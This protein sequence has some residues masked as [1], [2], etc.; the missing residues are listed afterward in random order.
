MSKTYLELDEVDRLEEAAGYLRDKLLIRVLFHLG[1]RISEA[2]GVA[3]DDVDF[4]RGTVTIQHLKARTKL[5][6]PHCSAHLG[7]AHRFCPGA[8]LR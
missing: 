4:V 5:S 7:H 8:G 3:V 6:C 2:L 1:C